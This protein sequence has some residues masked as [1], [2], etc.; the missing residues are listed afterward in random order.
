[1]KYVP[2]AVKVCE[3]TLNFSLVV[4]L[5]VEA[6]SGSQ[7]APICQFWLAHIFR[8]SPP[9][10]PFETS[11]KFDPAW[12]AAAMAS[13]TSFI[14]YVLKLPNASTPKLAAAASVGASARANRDSATRQALDLCMTLLL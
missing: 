10:R 5:S 9:D 11:S 14:E 3:L 8:P 4:A 12:F 13:F 7:L 1:M 2:V 6:R